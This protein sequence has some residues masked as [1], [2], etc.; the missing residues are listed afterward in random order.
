MLLQ[1]VSIC[2]FVAFLI[3]SSNHSS[4]N[5][6]KK[7]KVEAFSIFLSRAEWLCV[8]NFCL[9]SREEVDVSWGPTVAGVD[10]GMKKTLILV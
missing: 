6:H 10:F 9:T 4:S 5:D 3:Q 7:L 8:S 1:N 2:N